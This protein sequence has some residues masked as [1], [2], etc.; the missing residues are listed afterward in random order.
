MSKQ[1]TEKQELFLHVLFEE[2][3]GDIATA[4]KLAG[5]ARGTSTTSVVKAIKDEIIEATKLY[6]ARNAPQA[7]M[8]VV[9][10]IADPTQLGIKDKLNAAKDLLDRSGLIKAE[11]LQ[12]QASGG[13]MIL[14][15]KEALEEDDE[16]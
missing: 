6:M 5:Y 10:G 16:D 4:A 1:L 15:P 7:A 14:P 11:K 2:A 13:V 8:A 3:N 12:V 9:S